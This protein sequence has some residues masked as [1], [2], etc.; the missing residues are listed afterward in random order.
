M[1]LHSLSIFAVVVSYHGGPTAWPPQA[2]AFNRPNAELVTNVHV[3][4]SLSPVCFSLQMLDTLNSSTV[5]F[6]YLL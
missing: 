6:T 3:V 5:D 2:E 1:P 4:S